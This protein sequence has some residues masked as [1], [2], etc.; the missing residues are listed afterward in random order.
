MKLTPYVEYLLNDAFSLLDNVT[1]KNMFGGYGFYLDGKIFGFTLDDDTLVFKANEDMKDKFEKR[2]SKQFIYEGHK[3]KG[4]VAM[5]Y[6][7]VPE[8][9]IEDR[10]ELANWARASASLSSKK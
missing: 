8:G 2:G 3:N 6:W 10:S 1:V 9:V 4:P 7:S 5:P